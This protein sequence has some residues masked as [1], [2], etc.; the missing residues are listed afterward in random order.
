MNCSKSTTGGELYPMEEIAS[1]MPE[2]ISES[3]EIFNS[4]P[5]RLSE[6]SYCTKSKCHF[7]Q[8]PPSSIPM[9]CTCSM[10]TLLGN[11]YMGMYKSTYCVITNQTNVM[12]S[13]NNQEV[14]INIIQDNGNSIE[15]VTIN[16]DQVMSVRIASL[17]SSSVQ[18]NIA[19]QCSEVIDFTILSSEQ[20]PEYFNDDI[21]KG[22]TKSFQSYD[23]SELKDI[24]QVNVK[25]TIQSMTR[26]DQVITI[27]IRN[28]TWESLQ[29]NISQQ[30]IVEVIAQ[31]IAKV[32]LSNITREVLKSNL[33]NLEFVIRDNL[34]QKPS[35]KYYY[36]LL[37]FLLLLPVYFLKINLK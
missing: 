25:Q 6:D 3:I 22:I 15:N 34:C 37:I 7:N 9:S 2:A 35:S 17:T 5:C 11:M 1:F 29:F 32:S 13:M 20:N 21:S 26:V 19:E 8:T 30:N 14:R 28:S 33:E 31:N 18:M 24:V 4:V 10:Y 23:A 27:T 36:I 12:Y 16:I